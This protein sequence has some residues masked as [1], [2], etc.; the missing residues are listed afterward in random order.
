MLPFPPLKNPSN[1]SSLNSI[2]ASAGLRNVNSTKVDAWSQSPEPNS[3]AESK[4]D[5]SLHARNLNNFKQPNNLTFTDHNLLIDSKRK[6]KDNINMVDHIREHE[7]VERSTQVSPI[8]L[9]S[10]DDEDQSAQMMQE[11]MEKLNLEAQLE[12]EAAVEE[13]QRVAS[14]T[15][16]EQIEQQLQQQQH[17]RLSATLSQDSRHSKLKRTCQNQ[18]FHLYENEYPEIRDNLDVGTK[19]RDS[20]AKYAREGPHAKFYKNLFRES[21]DFILTTG[22]FM[23]EEMKRFVSSPSSNTATNSIPQNDIQSSRRAKENQFQDFVASSNYA[24][25]SNDAAHRPKQQQRAP[26]DDSQ[27]NNDPYNNSDNIVDTDSNFKQLDTSNTDAEC[28]VRKL[29]EDYQYVGSQSGHKYFV[30]KRS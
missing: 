26:N 17:G 11:D 18:N 13:I 20:G 27:M 29:N 19:S 2:I 5:L 14:N 21:P 7:I 8:L 22:K 24:D 30:E 4:T 25:D 12:E 15:N 1:L 16:S 28:R 3:T 9:P 23:D 10:A 6:L